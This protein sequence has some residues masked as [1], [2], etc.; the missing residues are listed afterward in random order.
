MKNLYR[1]FSIGFI[2]CLTL[3]LTAQQD[4]KLKI[5]HLLGEEAFQFGTE[6]SNSLGHTFTLIRMQYYL[7]D[8][9]IIHDGGQETV[10]SDTYLLASGDDIE[11]YA[12][13]EANF[14]D[15]ES[16]SFKIGVD[17]LNNHADPA[18]WPAD[19][20]LAPKNPSTHWG[21]S[22]GYR[23]L[24]MEGQAGMQTPSEGFEVHSLGDILYKGIVTLNVYPEDMGDHTLIEIKADYVQALNNID[25]SSGLIVHASD[26]EAAT[27]ISNMKTY[28]FSEVGT[29]TEI[30]MIEENHSSLLVF[31]NPVIGKEISYT[32][33]AENHNEVQL[34]LSDINGKIIIEKTLD[35]ITGAGTLSVEES[36]NYIL[37]LLSDTQVIASQK[38]SID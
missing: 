21:W 28:V 18:L 34:L 36:G 12:L 29:S 24:M 15:I 6:H 3:Q 16:I 35:P 14:T 10:L 33:Q 7:S 23:F 37:L 38:V 26:N 4:I 8:L 20:P 1:L 11:P 32:Y 19:H 22:G 5:H 2:M 9:R 31:P 17:S 25:L 30:D 13:G 27:V